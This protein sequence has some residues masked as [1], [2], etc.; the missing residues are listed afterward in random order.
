MKLWNFVH[1]Q[2]APALGFEVHV[3]EFLAVILAAVILIIAVVH[4]ILQ[5]RRA[6]KYEKRLDEMADSSNP[7]A[8][9]NTDEGEDGEKEGAVI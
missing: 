8:K 7:W 1:T 5:R 9:D 2:L 4:G 6:K 3:W